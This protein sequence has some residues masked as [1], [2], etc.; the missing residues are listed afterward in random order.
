MKLAITNE[1]E[2]KDLM[3]ICI[4][5]EEFSKELNQYNYEDIDLETEENKEHYK[6]LYPI[7]KRAENMEEFMLE[8]FKQFDIIHFRR[9]LWNLSTMLVNC[10]DLSKDDLDFN[11]EIKAGQDAIELLREFDKN[12]S[13]NHTHT[14]AFDGQIHNKIK[15]I[16]SKVPV[17]NELSQNEA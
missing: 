7:W 6:I 5:L 13:P 15:T 17:D 12:L 8:C 4:E 1:A 2:I 16:L 3:N 10:A 11:E 9:I 14:V